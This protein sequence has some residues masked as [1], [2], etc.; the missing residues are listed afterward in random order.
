MNN[1]TEV[2]GEKVYV[3]KT[4]SGLS[5]LNTIESSFLEKVS[6]KVKKLS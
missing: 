4:S 6:N 5:I 3:G 1:D 2:V